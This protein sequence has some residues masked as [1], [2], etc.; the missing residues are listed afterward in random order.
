MEVRGRATTRPLL[1]ATIESASQVA[2]FKVKGQGVNLTPE[3][4]AMAGAGC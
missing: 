2:K 4:E 1:A 3:E